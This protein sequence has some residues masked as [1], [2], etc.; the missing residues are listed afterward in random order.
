MGM[1]RT[2]ARQVENTMP[3]AA[4]KMHTT[5]SDYHHEWQGLIFDDNGYPALVLDNLH[6]RQK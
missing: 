2:Y 1:Q 4:H 6:K 5:H 3:L